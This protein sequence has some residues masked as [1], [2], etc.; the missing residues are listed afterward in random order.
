MYKN[1]KKNLFVYKYGKPNMVE[2]H[3]KFLNIIKNLE[4]YLNNL[5][6]KE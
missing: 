3:K 2:N 4:I 6:K 5:L 1:I